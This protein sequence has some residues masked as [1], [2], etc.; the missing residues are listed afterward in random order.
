MVLIGPGIEVP[1]QLNNHNTVVGI[2]A[3]CYSGRDKKKYLRSLHNI[4]GKTGYS[5]GRYAK[6]H[7][8]CKGCAIQGDAKV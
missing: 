8:Q 1:V 7:L 4:F 3:L 6:R 5:E 2:R